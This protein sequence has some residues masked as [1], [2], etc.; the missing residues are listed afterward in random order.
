MYLE[1]EGGSKMN[2]C[3]LIAAAASLAWSGAVQGQR[4]TLPETRA[5]SPLSSEIKQSYQAV[6]NNIIKSAQEMPEENYSFK[7]TPEIRSFAQVLGHVAEAQMHTCSAVL[8]TPKSIDTASKTSKADLV[9]ALQEAFGQC[10][11]AYETLTDA[12]ASNMIKTPHGQRT[13]MGALVANTIHDT[14]QYGILAV[15]LRLKGLVPPSSQH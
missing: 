7:P 5:E 14:E 12:D 13:K 2:R 11:K 6:K 15:Y 9:A 1:K 10:D 4:N 8:G 3:L